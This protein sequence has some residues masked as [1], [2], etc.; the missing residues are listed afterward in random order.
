MVLNFWPNMRLTVLIAVVLE[1]ND[2]E[3]ENRAI[4]WLIVVILGDHLIQ[5]IF[6]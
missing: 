4:F 3:G 1:N 5:M 6:L 2:L